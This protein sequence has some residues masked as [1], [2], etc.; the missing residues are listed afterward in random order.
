MINELPYARAVADRYA[1]DHHELQ[2]S[3]PLAELLEKM[4]DVYDEPFAD[5]SNIPTF[6]V[7][8]YASRSVKV[9]LSGDGGDELFG[10]YPWNL[11]RL[12]DLR[13]MEDRLQPRETWSRGGAGLACHDQAEFA[14]W[15]ATP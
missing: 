14:P 15:L 13:L 7:A 5:S 3:M 6:V 8:E 4:V 11:P 10:G 9:V 2:M 1:T 12:R